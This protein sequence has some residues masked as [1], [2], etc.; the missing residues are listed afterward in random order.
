MCISLRLIAYSV[1]YDIRYIDVFTIWL[2]ACILLPLP[3][4]QYIY[5]RQERNVTRGARARKR[6][7]MNEGEEESKLWISD[8]YVKDMEAIN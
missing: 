4:L 7:G 5:T 6:T 8:Y 2:L 3:L 1:V